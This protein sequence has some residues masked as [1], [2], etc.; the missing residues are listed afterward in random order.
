MNML[1]DG[2][3]DHLAS[4]VVD[5]G[6]GNLSASTVRYASRLLLDMIGCAVGG[7]AIDAG[8]ILAEAKTELGG[9]PEATML[10]TGVRTSCTSAAYVNAGL[11]VMLDADDTY[12]WKGHHGNC[13][14]MPAL[15][16]AERIGASGRDLALAIALG[17]EVAARVGKAVNM[18]TEYTPEHGLHI[19]KNAGMSWIIFGAAAA[20]AKLLRLDKVQTCHA[21]GIAATSASLPTSGQWA[22]FTHRRPMTKWTFTAPMAE[23]G[24]MAAILAGKGFA[25]DPQVFDHDRGFWRMAGASSYDSQELYRPKDAPWAVE[26]TSI[27][28]YPA[29][30][31]TNGPLDALFRIIKTDAP[32]W[33]DI[34]EI[35]VFACG[36]AQDFGALELGNQTDAAFNLPHLFAMAL[37]GMEPGPQ[38]HL[39]LNDPD[40][41]TLGRKVKILPYPEADLAIASQDNRVSRVPH[42]VE[43][44]TRAGTLR[45][46]GEYAHGDPW[47]EEMRM[48][49]T[50]IERKF[51]Q[52]S[53]GFLRH[54]KIDQAIALTRDLSKVAKVSELVSC[55]H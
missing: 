12:A 32:R 37:L 40:A 35:R 24:L 17:F 42:R 21:F 46:G 53:A 45:A 39:R 48:S 51:A 44:L 19:K 13:T 50:E 34:E 29:C 6:F 14:V 22:S 28:P 31:F 36:R 26:E 10:V 27:K 25:S 9:T 15:A 11:S 47:P 54:S 5:T 8:K 20:A 2:A 18:S 30:R 52:Y 3:T 33:Q 4:L 1:A 41:Q 49:D 55:L 38:W 43:V 7:F 16:M 23:A